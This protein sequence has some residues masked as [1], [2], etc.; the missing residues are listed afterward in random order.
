MGKLYLDEGEDEAGTRDWS[1]L[2]M[3]RLLLGR[4]RP[5]SECGE[6]VQMGGGVSTAVKSSGARVA[7][8]SQVW[9]RVLKRWV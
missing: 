1:F 6:R 7:G 9:E 3:K 8:V 5:L 4:H 2:S